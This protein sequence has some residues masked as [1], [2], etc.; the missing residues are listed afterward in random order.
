MK[1]NIGNGRVRNPGDI[2]AFHLYDDA[3][4]EEARHEVQSKALR[5]SRRGKGGGRHDSPRAGG[6]RRPGAG[7][8]HGR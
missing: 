3:A 4:I 7:Q 5:Q 2:E 8:R 1:L 6:S